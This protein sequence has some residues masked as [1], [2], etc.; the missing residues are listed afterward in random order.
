MCDRVIDLMCDGASKVE[1]CAD[2]DICYETFQRW[3]EE[4]AQFSES[5]KKGEMLSQAWW[6][7]LGR[8]G[9]SA[10]VDINPTTW[11]FNMKNRF[12]WS[13]KQ[14]VKQENTNTHVVFMAP[15]EYE[16]P[17]SWEQSQNSE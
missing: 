16:D 5:V 12:S 4:H 9:A 6:E 1:V 15:D 14:E 7:K 8:Q 13:D 11:I 17:E 10:A 3:Q 2:L